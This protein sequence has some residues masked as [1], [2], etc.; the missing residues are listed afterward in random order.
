[1]IAS[2]HYLELLAVLL[3]R[4]VEGGAAV[5]VEGG[6]ALGLHGRGETVL[7]DGLA[8]GLVHCGAVFGEGGHWK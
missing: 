7:K 1:M 6:R 2:Q 3:V 4:R 8:L 5:G